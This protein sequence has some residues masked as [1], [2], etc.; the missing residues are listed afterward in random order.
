MEILPLLSRVLVDPEV[1]YIIELEKSWQ[2]KL[3]W[4]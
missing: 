3:F 1:A 4:G 2:W